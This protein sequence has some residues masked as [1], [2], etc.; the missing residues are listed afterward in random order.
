MAL[1]VTKGGERRARRGR[2]KRVPQISV[3]P[4]AASAPGPSHVCHTVQKQ[5]D[6]QARRAQGGHSTSAQ[7]ACPPCKMQCGR[8]PAH[9]ACL[10]RK[11]G[12]Q[13]HE[14]R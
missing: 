14:L 5:A 9:P 2:R 10:Q 6:R 4:A 3:V 1:G 12:T 13:V 8:R 11:C 7:R